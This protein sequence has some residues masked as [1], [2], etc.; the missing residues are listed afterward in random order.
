M[1]KDWFSHK[2]DKSRNVVINLKKTPQ[3][4]TGTSLISCIRHPNTT[5]I[6]HLVLMGP[7]GVKMTTARVCEVSNKHIGEPASGLDEITT[8]SPAMKNKMTAYFGIQTLD[9]CAEIEW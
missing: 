9:R 2:V 1:E 8:S 3:Q 7:I 4:H 6:L 5:G